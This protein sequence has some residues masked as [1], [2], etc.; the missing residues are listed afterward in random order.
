[1]YSVVVW[2]C[3]SIVLSTVASSFSNLQKAL[4]EIL[5]RAKHMIILL[6]RHKHALVNEASAPCAGTNACYIEQLGRIT[7]W[8]PRYRA[9]TPDMVPPGQHCK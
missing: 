8:M 4:N 3:A 5:A 9:R 1:M 6:G 7:K 2:R